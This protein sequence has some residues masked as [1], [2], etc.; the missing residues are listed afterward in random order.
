MTSK[1]D[2]IIK[3][4]KIIFCL[5]NFIFQFV[6]KCQ[7]FPK[8]V[9]AARFNQD[10]EWKRRI[11]KY[12]M[13][14]VKYSEEFGRNYFVYRWMKSR[15]LRR[16]FILLPRCLFLNWRPLL[17]HAVLSA[18]KMFWLHVEYYFLPL[19]ETPCQHLIYF[20]QVLIPRKRKI[21]LRQIIYVCSI[22]KILSVVPIFQRV[23][24]ECKNG[25]KISL[26]FDMTAG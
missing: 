16:L 14:K 22:Q 4:I 10:Y 9:K 18:I 11:P 1:T 8:N 26:P 19:T 25:L 5:L 20:H 23:L 13:I 24:Q 12:I 21:D 3:F 7:S 17:I 15:P 2:N 6:R